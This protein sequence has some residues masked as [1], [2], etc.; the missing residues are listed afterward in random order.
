MRAVTVR[1]DESV[2]V[3]RADFYDSFG[4]ADR[5]GRRRDTTLNSCLRNVTTRVSVSKPFVETLT[6]L[7]SSV[8][9]A[10]VGART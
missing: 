3:N 4:R 6:A 9:T 2:S 1:Q 10:L 5:R 7:V 8:L